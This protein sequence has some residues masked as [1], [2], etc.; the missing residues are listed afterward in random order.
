MSKHAE[1]KSIMLGKG[2]FSV[3]GKPLGLTRDGGKFTV[4]Y[5]YRKIEA[6]GD[7]GTVQGR[8][9]K[10]GATPK[11]EINHLELLTGLDL[12]HPGITIDKSSEQG[13][14]VI[15]GNKDIDDI[16]DYH[17][18]T[19]NGETKDGKAVTVEIVRAINLE[20]LDWEFKAKN[21]VLDKLTFTGTYEEN[22]DDES[23]EGWSVKYQN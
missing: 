3:D 21:E 2:V 6:D 9:L 17:T 11:M 18:V 15:K 13:Y 16:K 14:T 5:E 1:P 12:L 7:R 4:E 22:S 23:D 10:E 19:F 20:N 8:V